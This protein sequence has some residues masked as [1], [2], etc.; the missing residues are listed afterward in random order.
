MG[1]GLEDGGEEGEG[2]LGRVGVLHGDD[3]AKTIEYLALLSAV[4]ELL[5]LRGGEGTGGLAWAGI[6]GCFERE[7]AGWSMY[8]RCE[9]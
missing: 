3:A 9:W 7:V 1:E 2:G 6:A 4:E 5:D 8:V